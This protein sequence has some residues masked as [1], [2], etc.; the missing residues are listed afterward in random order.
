MAALTNQVYVSVLL[1]TL[2]GAALTKTPLR[3]SLY[4][5]GTF[6]MEFLL[7]YGADATDVPSKQQQLAGRVVT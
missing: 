2:Q 1:S 3:L 5:V 6:V 4:A 7:S